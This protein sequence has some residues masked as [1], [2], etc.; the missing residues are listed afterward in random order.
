MRA[1]KWRVQALAAVAAAAMLIVPVA[2]AARAASDHRRGELSTRAE[3]GRGV[4]AAPAGLRELRLPGMAPALL[5]VPAGYRSER[6]IPLV[7]MLHGAGGKPRHSIDLVRAHADRLGFAIL[8]PGSRGS[9]WDLVAARRFGAD[10]AAIDRLLGQ[11]FADYQVDPQRIGI[12]GFSDGASYALSLG[13]ANG[14]LFGFVLAFS[15]GF[16]AS[17]RQQGRPRIFVSHGIQDRILA[18]DRCSRRI[19]PELRR[20]GYDV[21]YVEFA[22]GHLV[23]AE[24]AAEAFSMLGAAAAPTA[25]AAPT[26]NDVVAAADAES[27]SMAPAIL[28]EGR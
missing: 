22:G 9:S 20:V 1:M 2:G 3:V 18:I 11:V 8:A 24:L 21:N 27:L 12:A 10:V 7:V 26:P 23:P 19:V 5:Y 15:P 16:A 6:P 25:R 14:E 13:L 28:G 4:G 17:A